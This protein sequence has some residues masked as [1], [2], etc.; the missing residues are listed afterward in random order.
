MMT[1]SKRSY[2]LTIKENIKDFTRIKNTERRGMNKP[3]D[4]NIVT[5]RGP[6]TSTIQLTVIRY[7]SNN[8]ER[9]LQTGREC[10]RK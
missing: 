1:A 4:E 8:F 7:N 10:F 2:S 5:T 3:L 6:K 9:E